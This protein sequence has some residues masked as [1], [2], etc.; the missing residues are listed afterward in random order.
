M[1]AAFA[2]E[3]RS[4]G[5]ARNMNKTAKLF[6]YLSLSEKT[7]IFTAM[8]R[9]TIRAHC[10]RC[11]HQQPFVRARFHWKAHLALT[12]LT[13]G[14]WGVCMLSM[15]VKRLIWPWRCEHCGWHEPDFRSK[16]ERAGGAEKPKSRSGVS[17]IS[18]PDSR[19]GISGIRRPAP[20]LVT[21]EKPLDDPTTPR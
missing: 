19:S 3:K 7:S 20:R 21:E 18:R 9:R 10:P 16:E 14:I 13:C 12:V 6:Y 1:K 8:S 5:R 4:S 11:R 15:I 2:A 17:G